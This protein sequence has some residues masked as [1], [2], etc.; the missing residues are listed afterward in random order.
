MSISCTL[1]AGSSASSGVAGSEAGSR[2]AVKRRKPL[3]AG[4]NPCRMPFIESM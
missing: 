4:E 2:S 3:A 1:L